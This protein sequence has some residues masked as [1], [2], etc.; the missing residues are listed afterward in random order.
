MRS[1]L[2]DGKGDPLNIDLTCKACGNNRFSFSEAQTDDA[3]ILC[4]DCG[5]RVGTL[6]SLKAMVE[7]AVLESVGRTESSV[8]P[9]VSVKRAPT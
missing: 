8:Q 5:H 1:R 4:I 2:N 3:P 9:G 7:Q 6:G